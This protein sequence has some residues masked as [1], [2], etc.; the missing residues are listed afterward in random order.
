M[1]SCCSAEVADDVLA[2]LA[3]SGIAT[4]CV[5]GIALHKHLRGRWVD[6]ISRRCGLRFDNLPS[7]REGQ[8]AR[9]LKIMMKDTVY[10]AVRLQVQAQLGLAKRV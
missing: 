1:C 9:L 4:P 6:A 7:G 8:Y 2:A 5:A 10:P 3:Q